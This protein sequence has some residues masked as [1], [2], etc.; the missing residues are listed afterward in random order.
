[1]KIEYIEVSSLEDVITNA[2]DEISDG[3]SAIN[4]VLAFKISSTAMKESPLRD[5]TEEALSWAAS[6][7]PKNL[8]INHG[9]FI[10]DGMTHIIDELENKKDS[11]RALFSLISQE[12]ISKSLDN[13]IPSFMLMQCN[14]HEE[15]LYCTT[16]FRALEITKFLRVNLEEIRLKIVEIHDRLL[17]F[18]KINVTIIAFRAYSNKKI[19]ALT[20]PL[21]DRMNESEITVDLMTQPQK[22]AKLLREKCHDTTVINVDS[23]DKLIRSL[24]ALT[25]QQLNFNRALVTAKANDLQ[26]ASTE[27]RELR[28]RSSHHAQISVINNKINT[29]TIA[30]AEELEK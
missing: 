19:N 24:S 20:I 14:I 1:L 26:I 12:N 25:N 2:T 30:I 27:L 4:F 13:P 6:V 10:K 11:N 15:T 29:L 18:K 17:S 22:I 8:Y 7:R 3:E 21:F 5:V 9:E 16:Y 28:A 23:I